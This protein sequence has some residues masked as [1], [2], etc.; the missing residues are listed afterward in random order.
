[1]KCQTFCQHIA[2]QS[3]EESYVFDK[4]KYALTVG[5]REKKMILAEQSEKND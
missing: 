4:Y 1:M 3:K 5:L 2:I